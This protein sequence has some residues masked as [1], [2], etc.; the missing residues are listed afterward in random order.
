[1][2]SYFWSIFIKSAVRRPAHAHNNHTKPLHHQAHRSLA[3]LSHDFQDAGDT[4]RSVCR[5]EV[6]AAS[7][8]PSSLRYGSAELHRSTLGTLLSPTA[9]A[10]CVGT[11][12]LH[13]A[14]LAKSLDITGCQTASLRG[15][16]ITEIG[17]EL[18]PLQ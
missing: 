9:V 17:L 18:P 6:S 2:V 14:T 10:L 4:L 13:L 15:E 3:L 7:F 1:M 12:F 11:I 16:I 5:S 8:I